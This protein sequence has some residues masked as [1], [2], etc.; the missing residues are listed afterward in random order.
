MDSP[1]SVGIGYAP[2]L[3]M[4]RTTRTEP[5]PFLLSLF[6]VTDVVKNVQKVEK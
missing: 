4:L 5:Y 3:N 6:A 1:R 2:L